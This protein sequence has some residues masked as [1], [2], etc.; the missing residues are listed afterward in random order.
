MKKIYVL[1][2]V[3]MGVVG[4]TAQDLLYFNDFELGLGTATVVGNG[5]LDV[6]PTPGFGAVFHNAAG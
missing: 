6:D 4:S 3:M 5:V 1:L 2:F